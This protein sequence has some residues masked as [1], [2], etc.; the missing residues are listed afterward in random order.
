LALITEDAMAPASA[1]LAATL[2][3]A[4]RA[5]M[6]GADVRAAVAESSFS[7]VTEHGISYRH[8]DLSDAT[9]AARWPDVIPADAA[10]DPIAAVHDLAMLGAPPPAVWG[11]AT[12]P[13]LGVLDPTQDNP[14]PDLGPGEARAGLITVHGALRF[15]FEYFDVV[16]DVID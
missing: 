6:F 3:L 15:W 14:P 8:E 12:R 1:E 2:R 9:T 16:G 10:G 5:W 7:P 13:L 11:P 4:G